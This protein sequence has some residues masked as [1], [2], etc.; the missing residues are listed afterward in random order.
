V[1]REKAMAVMIC[2]RAGI[3]FDPSFAYVILRIARRIQRADTD[4][5]NQES[6]RW[7][8]RHQ[9]RKRFPS[10]QSLGKGT[11]GLLLITRDVNVA[12]L[13]RFFPRGRR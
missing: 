4:W 3:C 1:E 11:Y 10:R 6:N 8:E 12:D 7:E 5:S 2:R 9:R 13:A